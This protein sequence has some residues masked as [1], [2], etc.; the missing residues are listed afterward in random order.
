[1]SVFY[2][3]LHQC[4]LISGTNPIAQLSTGS[5]IDLA[6]PYYG[7]CLRGARSVTHSLNHHTAAAVDLTGKSTVSFTTGKYTQL[8]ENS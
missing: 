7:M 3:A 1:M 2:N 5:D 8:A 6:F 4:Y